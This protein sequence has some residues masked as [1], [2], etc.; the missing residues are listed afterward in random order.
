MIGVSHDRDTGEIVL[1]DSGAKKIYEFTPNKARNLA[2]QLRTAAR[3]GAAILIVATANHGEQARIGG[4]A[5]DAIRMA[6]DIERNAQLGEN[7]SGRKLRNVSADFS[8]KP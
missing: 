5:D 8:P 1:I 6:D 2:V 3:A 4:E 7:L